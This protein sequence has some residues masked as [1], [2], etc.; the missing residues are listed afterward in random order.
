M[1]DICL[2]VSCY[3]AVEY[4]LKLPVYARCA[5]HKN[6]NGISKHINLS[7]TPAILAFC[8]V[9]CPWA[10]HVAHPHSR[11]QLLTPISTRKF[12][13]FLPIYLSNSILLSPYVSLLFNS[14]S[15]KIL[16]LKNQI[17]ALLPYFCMPP[18]LT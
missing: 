1:S 14:F 17:L 2:L 13:L 10:A 9:P 16:S 18:L 6:V 11:P 12:I 7:N 4:I 15:T 3:Y 8:F 5:L